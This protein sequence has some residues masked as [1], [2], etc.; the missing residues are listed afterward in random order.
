MPINL[1]GAN[2][3][4]HPENSHVLPEFIRR[5]VLAK[6]ISELSVSILRTG[7]VRKLF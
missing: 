3:N 1:Y 6:R 2:Y 4:Y 5:I 7:I